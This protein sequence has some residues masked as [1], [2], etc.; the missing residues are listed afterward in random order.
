[1]GAGDA[2]GSGEGE[3]E[4]EGEGVGVGV[5]VGVGSGEAVAVAVGEDV[6]AAVAGGRSSGSLVQADSESARAA[7][8]RS[9]SERRAQRTSMLAPPG[10]PYEVNDSSGAMV[11]RG[12]GGGGTAMRV[13]ER[14]GSMASPLTPALMGFDQQPG[15]SGRLVPDPPA[16]EHC[17]APRP[18]DLQGETVPRLVRLGCPQH[19]WGVVP[20]S[21]DH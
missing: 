17:L 6:A 11:P 14:G 19:S 1:M 21:T 20:S 16:G 3:G 12:G 9:G 5:G 4:G 13:R 8:I 2:V 7:A 15:V 10:G 18:S